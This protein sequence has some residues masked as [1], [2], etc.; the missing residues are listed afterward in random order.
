MELTTNKYGT[1]F[2][3]DED[4]LKLDCDEACTDNILIL[5]F[6]WVNC[7]LYLKAFLKVKVANAGSR[8]V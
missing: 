1:P 7:E 3:R 2:M 5:Y 8:Y 6:K 4:V